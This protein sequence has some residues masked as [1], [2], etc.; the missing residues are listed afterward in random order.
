[1]PIARIWP[2]DLTR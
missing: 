2:H 1:M